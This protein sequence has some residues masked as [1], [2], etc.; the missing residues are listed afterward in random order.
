MDS[1]YSTS[2]GV[3]GLGVVVVDENDFILRVA[4]K[5]VPSLFAPL[6][7]IKEGLRL[8]HGL[9]LDS[10][11]VLLNCLTIVG[12]LCGNSDSNY[13]SWCRSVWYQ[14]Y[15]ECILVI[16][17]SSYWQIIQQG[18]SFSCKK[19]SAHR[20]CSWFNQF[21]CRLKDVGKLPKTIVHF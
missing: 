11:V 10:M 3:I 14:H 21:P 8:A 6:L 13:W 12:L 18:C 19:V 4:A 16:G 15:V 20:P 17:V 1:S 7:A 2:R 9:L 5:L